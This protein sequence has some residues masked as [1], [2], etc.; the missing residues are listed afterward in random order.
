MDVS[1]AP[2]GKACG[3]YRIE[4]SRW[5]HGLTPGTRLRLYLVDLPEGLWVETLAVTIV[6][7]K[8]R[9]DEV[10]EETKPIIESIEFHP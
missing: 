2:G 1:L 10:I 9:F 6:A 5:I 4:I 3:V 7:P 8:D